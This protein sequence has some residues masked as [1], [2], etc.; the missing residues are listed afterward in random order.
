MFF[1]LD[2]CHVDGWCLDV[3]WCVF[4]V[5]SWPRASRLWAREISQ[6]SASTAPTTEGL[7]MGRSTGFIV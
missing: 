5:L 2:A 3:C 6:E 7:S 4:V 1:F